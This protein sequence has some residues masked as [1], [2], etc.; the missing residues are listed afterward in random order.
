ME[1]KY[2]LMIMTFGIGV[3]LYAQNKSELNE[4]L[5]KMVEQ[6]LELLSTESLDAERDYSSLFESLE[7]YALRPLNLNRAS[8]EDLRALGFLTEFQIKDLFL[9]IKEHGA[10][11]T[12]E[13]LLSINGFEPQLIRLIRPFVK[14]NGQDRQIDPTFSALMHEGK[15][16]LF[17]RHHRTLQKTAAY[18][19][20]ASYQGS[21]DQL[22]MRYRFQYYQRLS[23]GLTAEKDA[24]EAFFRKGQKQGFDFYSGHIFLR[25]WKGI[26]QLAIGDFQAQYGQGLTYWSGLAFSGSGRV[27]GLK[28][29]AVRLSPYTS[30]EENQFLRG[31][32]SSFNISVFKL[33]LFLSSRKIDANVE[34]N[35]GSPLVSSFGGSGLHRHPAE[36]DKKSRLHEL[37]SGG[38]L[39]YEKG[40]LKVGFTA[41]MRQFGLPLENDRRLYQS[42][43][44]RNKEQ[45]N[46]GV[47]YHYY[48]R[49]LLLFGEIARSNNGGIAM[50]QG[51]LW[52]GNRGFQ[53]GFLQRYY[54]VDYQSIQSNALGVNS[55]NNNEI[56]S[57]LSMEIPLAK[58]LKANFNYDIYRH[59]WLRYQRDAPT[60]GSRQQ[61]EM[62]YRINR[63]LEVY[64][65]YQQIKRQ[66]NSSEDELGVKTIKEEDGINHRLHLTY[67]LS[68]TLKWQSR[69]ESRAHY[70]DSGKSKGLLIYQDLS[71]NQLNFPLRFSLRY[72]L[73]DCPSYESRIYAYERDV[74][75][76]FSIPAY[77]GIG[78]RYYL[79]VQWKI[80]RGLDFWVR[81][82]E[83]TYYDRGEI[84][85]GR[86][87][88]D[89]NR[90]SRI[91]TQIRWSF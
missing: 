56:G 23:I 5:M 91:K 1:I 3:Q 66:R 51:F 60:A 16:A 63:K 38:N 45:F 67:E 27:A 10:L 4:E 75:Y 48:L 62:R 22:Y 72:A 73:F 49:N 34:S 17:I 24:G 89:G 50:L 87:R 82:D 7:S 8:K 71:F 88:I 37:Q 83:T 33:S 79:L 26:E 18:Q 14:L 36:L 53:I 19:N 90:K 39:E 2:Y 30:S 28:R 61:L 57:S 68:E 70:F 6:R 21:P 11:L 86:D 58:K 12:L 74:L 65:R 42:F 54:Q 47:D 52:A 25:D 81:Y 32:G 78:A 15:S 85:S 46:L 64:Y 9:H 43:Q 77:N 31:I 29:T 20:P 84:G 13:E 44:K 69:I 59:P 41:A 55:G 35:S 80:R 76:A 40:D